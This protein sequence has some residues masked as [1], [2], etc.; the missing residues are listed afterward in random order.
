MIIKIIKGFFYTVLLAIIIVVMIDPHAYADA[1]TF[2]PLPGGGRALVGEAGEVLKTWDNQQWL[3]TIDELSTIGWDEG[4]YEGPGRE[5]IERGEFGQE[6]KERFGESGEQ[7]ILDDSSR[8]VAEGRSGDFPPDVV[9]SLDALGVDEGVL[10]STL[11]ASA[12]GTFT[13]GAAAVLGI[14]LGNGIDSLFGAE[15]WGLLENLLEEE[16]AKERTGKY[17]ELGEGE[18]KLELEKAPF[19]ITTY[20]TSCASRS[21]CGEKNEIRTEHEMPAGWY[22]EYV[23]RPGF[24]EEWKYITI[25]REK[26]ETEKTL[27]KAFYPNGQTH[28][29]TTESCPGCENREHCFVGGE[30][31]NFLLE[32]GERTLEPKECDYWSYTNGFTRIELSTKVHIGTRVNEE[33][34][35]FKKIYLYHKPS[36]C[37]AEVWEVEKEGLCIEP[38][39]IPGPGEITPEIEEYNKERGEPRKT[40]TPIELPSQPDTLKEHQVEKVLENPPARKVIEE[41]NKREQVEREKGLQVPAPGKNELGSNYETTLKSEGF[42]NIHEYTVSESQIDSETGPKDVT[43]VS[44]SPGTYVS[45]STAIE[46]SVNPD[47][48]PQPPPGEPPGGIP[49]VTPPGIKLPELHL[50]CTT[51]PFGAP[52]WLIK[53]IEAFSGAAAAPVWSIG[54]ISFAGHTIP[55]AEIHLSAIEPIM[56]IVRPFMVL[57]GI[58]G[59]V[60]LFY[61]I[62]TGHSIGRGEN[63][64]G[65]VPDPESVA[66][67]DEDIYL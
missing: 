8:I 57:F 22:L 51:M 49:G 33:N 52:C 48:A 45:A 26:G 14:E 46:Y 9:D 62:F 11:G 47:D 7:S 1:D 56:E 18:P 65:E 66:Y 55:K 61:R 54:P 4:F 36:E 6:L 53:Q 67:P 59:I 39:T 35:T 2:T 37:K 50:L 32:S 19:F 64:T 34:N 58:V 16:E 29:C 10:P 31:D 24:A 25:N 27:T 44:P 60:L 20:E 12:L 38:L 41:H 23:N 42:T 63:P 43:S 30:C 5:A 21:N 3:D 17:G 15:H 40:F 28:P 13:L